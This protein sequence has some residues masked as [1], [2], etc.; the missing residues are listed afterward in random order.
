ME[1]HRG[2]RTGVRSFVRVA[3]LMACFAGVSCSTPG[4]IPAALGPIFNLS[5]PRRGNILIGFI[6]N[7]SSQ[8]VFTFGGYD[9]LDEETAPSFAQIRLPPNSASNQLSQPCRRV[10]SIGGAD[11]IRLVQ[12]QGGVLTDPP[13]LI[14][15][16]NFSN[17]P[18][19][20]PLGAAP[21][22]GT[23]AP[24]TVS[25]GV[26]YSCDGLLLFIFERDTTVS[27][28]FR[29]DYSFVSAQ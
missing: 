24:R 7:T 8:A 3:A 23:A 1:S 16:V 29:I 26:D 14:T 6:N 9:P 27:G 18:N 28:G 25:V 19:N 20:D 21:T 22:E 11:L 4:A 17:A 12:A 2:K 15:G 13:A 10:F 5:V